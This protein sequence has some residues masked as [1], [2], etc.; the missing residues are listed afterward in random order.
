MEKFESI[1]LRW[2]V[3]ILVPALLGTMLVVKDLSAQQKDADPE[4]NGFVAPSNLGDWIDLARER[5]VTV[6][7]NEIT[8]SGFSFDFVPV[9]KARWSFTRSA[10]VK[11]ILLTNYHVIEPCM[12]SK[13]QVKIYLDEKTII[14][15]V[16]AAIDSDRDIAALSV[17]REI[18]PLYS[19]YYKPYSG[20]WVMA[21]GSPFAMDGTTTFGNIINQEGDKIFTSASLNKGNSGGPLVDNEGMVVGINTGYRAVAQNLNWAIDINALCYKIAICE[22]DTGLLH[23]IK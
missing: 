13:R 9:D 22:S 8:G 19:I 1:I 3:I 11:S 15:G 20:Y 5:T 12:K 10:E 21:V 23:P 18:E 17:N 4:F 16:I 2:M 14:D 6:S 7:C